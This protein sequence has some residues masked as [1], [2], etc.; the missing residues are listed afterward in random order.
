MDRADFPDINFVIFHLGLLFMD[1]VCWQ[2]V[3]YPTL[4]ASIAATITFVVRSLRQFAE[5]IG[6]LSFWCGE[7]KITYGSKTPIWR[8]KWALDA[9]LLKLQDT[10]R[11][12]RGLRLPAANPRD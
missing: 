9:F 2:L 12:R 3:R 11:P 6:K 7:D 5:R 8:P 1:E 10:R 4:Y